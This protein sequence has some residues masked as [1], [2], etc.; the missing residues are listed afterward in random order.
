MDLKKKK[1]QLCSIQCHPLRSNFVCLQKRYVLVFSPLTIKSLP[2]SVMHACSYPAV[3]G[4]GKILIQGEV[5]ASLYVS[6]VYKISSPT[7]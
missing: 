7:F 6:C 4:M 5:L 2:A 3:Q 1:S